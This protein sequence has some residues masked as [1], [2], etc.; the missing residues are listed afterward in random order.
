VAIT[1]SELRRNIYRLLDQVLE[2]GVPLEIQRG[3]HRLQISAAVGPSKLEGLPLR[4]LFECDP[5]ALVS[6]GMR[7]G[8]SDGEKR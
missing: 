8:S 2:T 7:D 6:S 4:N 5:D 1:A 3:D